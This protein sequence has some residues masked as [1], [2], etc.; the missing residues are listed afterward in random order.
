MLQKMLENTEPF[1]WWCCKILLRQLLLYAQI[2]PGTYFVP[3]QTLKLPHSTCQHYPCIAKI[4]HQLKPFRVRQIQLGQQTLTWDTTPRW[5]PQ[6][7]LGKRGGKKGPKYTCCS[8]KVF[9]FSAN[10]RNNR[11][12]SSRGR[13]P[14]KFVW[15]GWKFPIFC[16][17]ALH[18]VFVV[19]HGSRHDIGF[20]FLENK[21]VITFTS[22]LC[23]SLAKF[24]HIY[25]EIMVTKEVHPG[26]CPSSSNHSVLKKSTSRLN[27]H[28]PK[29]PG[30]CWNLQDLQ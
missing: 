29:I 21:L 5:V 11:R 2:C 1:C 10:Q 4:G 28:Q 18:I 30:N 16:S 9:F 25:F 8:Q 23:S 22:N 3:S 26:G 13:I 12:E 20:F 27:A 24:S 15:Q 17:Q 7:N 19:V 6:L 14:H